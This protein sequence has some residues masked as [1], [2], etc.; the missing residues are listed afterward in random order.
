M[1][2]HPL[3]FE[4]G[5]AVASIQRAR[6]KP[7]TEAS[8]LQFRLRVMHRGEIALGPGKIDLLMAI[9]TH[10]SIAKGAKTLGMSY[11]R[12]WTLV[13]VMNG[14][15]EEPL[16]ERE[17]GGPRGGTGPTHSLGSGD[18]GTLYQARRGMPHRSPGNM[19]QAGT[20]PEEEPRSP[21]LIESG[22]KSRSRWRV[23]ATWFRYRL[24]SIRSPAF[25][26]LI[27]R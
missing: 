9:Q 4:L 15:F 8:V 6:K 27:L 23:L 20:A 24:I 3:D 5:F 12:A 1:I 16:V 7:S 21:R 19:V 14:A 25:Q 22:S 17:R 2:D 26:P 18:S 10:G 13:K 11:M